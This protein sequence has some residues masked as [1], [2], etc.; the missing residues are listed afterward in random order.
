MFGVNWSDPQT[1][2]LNVTN[3]ALGLVVIICL[4]A[5]AFGVF[6]EVTARLRRRAA[7]RDLDREVREL[8][9]SY[10][11]GHA[12]HVPGLGVTMA[13]GGEPLDKKKESP[14]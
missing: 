10:G 14:F 6:Q 13:D 9:A 8:A 4:G 2:W 3:A 11:G 12:L 5:V 7:V 1:W